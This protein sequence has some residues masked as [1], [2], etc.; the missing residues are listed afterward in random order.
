MSLG[1][2]QIDF[3]HVKTARPTAKPPPYDNTRDASTA[4][5]K[6]RNKTRYTPTKKDGGALLLVGTHVGQLPQLLS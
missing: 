1:T 2:W 5:E 6:K 4:H 3:V